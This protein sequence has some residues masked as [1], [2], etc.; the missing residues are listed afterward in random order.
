[1][2]PAER[3]G[4][5]TAAGDGGAGGPDCTDI[6]VVNVNPDL[7]VELRREGLERVVYGVGD[8]NF[9]PSSGGSATYCGER[10]RDRSSV[11]RKRN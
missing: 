1:M 5:P 4:L 6:E 10:L 7:A 9:G 8:A 3:V 2:Q 11:T